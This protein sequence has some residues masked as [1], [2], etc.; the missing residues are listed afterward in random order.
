M[1]TPVK[2]LSC[3]NL[4]EAFKTHCVLPRRQRKVLRA[5]VYFLYFC[6]K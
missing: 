6:S 5:Y 2:Q 4:A 3:Q 1:A